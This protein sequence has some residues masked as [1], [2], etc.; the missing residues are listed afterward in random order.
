MLGETM[1][2]D[3]APPISRTAPV[4]HPVRSPAVEQAGALCQPLSVQLR[5]VA[6]TW[7][8]SQHRIVVLAAKFADSAEWV[9]DG[10]PTA[11]HW[12]VA[13]AL[14]TPAGSLGQALA[15]WLNNNSDPED[16]T[17]HQHRR[18]SIKWRTEPDGMV[19]FTLRLPPLLAGTLIAI[20]NAIVMRSR[21]IATK[22]DQNAS[23][24]A[25]PSVAQQNA[26]ALEQLLSG[27]AGSIDTEIVLHKRHAACSQSYLTHSALGPDGR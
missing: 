16:I 13:I 10:S 23:A 17:G 6:A 18:R 19:T 20:L 5:D 21:P 24:D 1:L 26:D 2:A 12:L 27:G 11:A 15:A 4:A 9:L 8:H 14:D 7:A 25:W 22:R 3:S